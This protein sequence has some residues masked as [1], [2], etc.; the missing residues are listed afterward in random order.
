MKKASSRTTKQSAKSGINTQTVREYE[1][2]LSP[3]T[4]NNYLTLVH[5]PSEIAEAF[6]SEGVKRVVAC[7]ISD[8]GEHQY[9]C[10]LLPVGA[11]KTGIMINKAIRTKLGIFEGARL[12]VRLSKDESKYGLE[13]PEEL[14]ELMRQDEEGDRLFHELTDG[15]R[16]SLIYLVSSV[17]NSERRIERAITV[18][19]HLKEHGGKVDYKRLYNDLKVSKRFEE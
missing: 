3:S 10:G 8:V 13:M 9:Q 15:K 19:E 18:I 6:K 14:A 5:V 4:S 1:T 12:R 2:I 17:K 16:R 11:G 7:L